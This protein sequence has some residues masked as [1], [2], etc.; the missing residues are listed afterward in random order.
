MRVDS[1]G[2][3]IILMGFVKGKN[4]MWEMKTRKDDSL[5]TGAM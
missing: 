2:R 3:K 4:G 5:V 1:L